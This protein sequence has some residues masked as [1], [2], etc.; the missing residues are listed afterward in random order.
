MILAVGLSPDSYIVKNSWGG[1]WGEAG[2][3]RLARNQ[4]GTSGGAC[5]IASQA[6]SPV[7]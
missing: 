4:S 5:S 3:A 2:F 1:G 7:L 6:S